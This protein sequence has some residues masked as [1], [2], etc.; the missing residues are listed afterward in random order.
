MTTTLVRP[1][2]PAADIV[3]APGRPPAP[4]AAGRRD[5][6]A[7]A[8]QAYTLRRAFARPASTR[9]R[10]FLFVWFRVHVRE[11]KRGHLERVNVK[12]PIP[13]PLIGALLPARMSGVQALKALGLAEAAPSGEGTAA[14]AAYV[15]SVMGF[16]FV[17]VEEDQPERERRS[18]VV[19]GFD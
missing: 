15:E 19:V 4:L 14:L 2:A 12:I 18:L 8:E 17:R 7:L 10:R 6:V 3:V 16:E 13:I 1:A 5:A 9:L 11:T